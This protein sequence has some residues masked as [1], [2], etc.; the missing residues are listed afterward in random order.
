MKRK[1]KVTGDCFDSAFEMFMANTGDQMVL[2]HGLPTGMSG[3]AAKVGTYPHAW[4]EFPDA[5]LVYD[6]VAGV[7]IDK[8]RYYH[9]GNITYTKR[10]DKNAVKRMLRKHGINSIVWDKTL[11]RRNK[12]ISKLR[13]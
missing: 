5:N 13:I 12:A 2:V 3:D 1:V 10:Y 6:T 8:D 9:L 4:I 11:I 7:T